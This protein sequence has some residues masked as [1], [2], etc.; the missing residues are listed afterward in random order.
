[1][2]EFPKNFLWGAATA[3]YQVDGANNTQ[4]AEWEQA[5]AKRLAR[6]M[7]KRF[8]SL[9]QDPATAKAMTDPANYICGDGVQHAKHYEADFDMLGQ[10]NLNAFRFGIEWARLEPEEGK[11]DEAAIAYYKTYIA[12]LKQRG[13]EPI[14]TLWHWTMPQWFTVKGGFEKRRNLQ[15]FDR[16]VEK[17]A[18]EFGNQL[19]YVLTLNEPNVYTAFGYLSGE[20]PPSQKNPLKA[21]V[22]YC[23]LGQ[24]HNRA[25]DLLKA[26]APKLQVGL[27][28][29]L[30]NIRPHRPRN[31]LNVLTAHVLGWLWNWWFLQ[32][33]RDRQD[34]IGVNYYFT[35]YR[36]WLGRL[37]NPRGPCNDLGWYMEPAGIA[38]MLE[39]AWQRYRKP[40]LITENGLADVADKHRQWWLAET[41]AAL[42]GATGNG[43]PVLGYL[44]WS[45]LDNFEWA[46]GW[47]PK[48]GL[49][50]VDRASMKRTIRPSAKWFAKQIKQVR[51]L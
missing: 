8:P 5:H 29:S 14:L 13:I 50:S 6:D 33:V 28:V 36:D 3:A 24:V 40:L 16:Y 31:P 18:Q 21:W 51:S 47:W 46:Y 11:W 22:V 4:W 38:N 45:L 49:V 43:I 7:P 26:S 19:Q 17:V 1:M 48:F 44:H 2:T 15:Y 41:L 39:A 42:Q 37:R 12:S 27:P 34:F 32:M 9:M 30:S 35:E 23:N 10:L 20:W 25:Y